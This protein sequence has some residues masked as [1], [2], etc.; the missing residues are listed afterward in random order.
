MNLSGGDSFTRTTHHSIGRNINLKGGKSELDGNVVLSGG[1]SDNINGGVMLETPEVVIRRQDLSRSKQDRASGDVMIGTGS[2]KP[3]RAIE[4]RPGDIALKSMLETYKPI[5]TAIS[6]AYGMY[7]NSYVQTHAAASRFH[8]VIPSIVL[9]A[10][11]RSVLEV[12]CMKE[13]E[14]P[15][16][17]RGT[18]E[19]SMTSGDRTEIA[20]E[21]QQQKQFGSHCSCLSYTIFSP[22]L[23]LTIQVA[24]CF[25]ILQAESYTGK[26]RIS[27]EDPDY[28]MAGNVD[29]AVY[30]S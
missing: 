30:C 27:T 3:K 9:G 15:N 29:T 13:V 16:L 12:D 24:A 19:I 17:K 11:R 22:S 5:T 20:G 6:Y 10:Q 25:Y 26:V 18:G 7:G 4:G 28:G 23:N 1:E 2:A 21:Y 14:S 8:P